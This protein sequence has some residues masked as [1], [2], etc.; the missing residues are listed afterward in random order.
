[1]L[2]TQIEYVFNLSR[3]YLRGLLML[4]LLAFVLAL[5]LQAMQLDGWPIVQVLIYALVSGL[6]IYGPLNLYFGVWVQF[7]PF[8]LARTLVSL[9]FAGSGISML[10]EEPVPPLTSVVGGGSLTLVSLLLLHG[11]LVWRAGQPEATKEVN[12]VTDASTAKPSAESC[13]C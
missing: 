7:S 9:V 13:S 8:E 1:M 6:L 2:K 3:L 4:L 10:F 12:T 5:V 11:Y